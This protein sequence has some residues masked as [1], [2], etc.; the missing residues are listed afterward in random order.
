MWSLWTI[1]S[2]CGI[3]ILQKIFKKIRV[4]YLFLFLTYLLLLIWLWTE[5]TWHSEAPS[6]VWCVVVHACFW[7]RER[8][9]L[10]PKTCPSWPPHVILCLTAVHCLSAALTTLTGGFSYRLSWELMTANEQGGPRPKQSGRKWSEKLQFP[11]L[12]TSINS[13]NV[14]LM[15]SLNRDT[16]L[17]HSHQDH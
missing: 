2:K 13:V 10:G 7:I 16:T 15:H 12:G 1:M 17:I 3:N 5:I 14:Q 9:K 4:N 8:G 11:S 6:M